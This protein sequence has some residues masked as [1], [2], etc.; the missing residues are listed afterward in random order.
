MDALDLLETFAPAKTRAAIR[1]AKLGIKSGKVQRGAK[2]LSKLIKKGKDARFRKAQQMRQHVGETPGS[3][4]AKNVQYRT[5]GWIGQNGNVLNG[6]E[7]LQL[8]RIDNTFKLNQ[9][10]RDIVYLQGF[11]ICVTVENIDSAITPIYF[12]L[13]LV[14]GKH[15]NTIGTGLDLFRSYSGDKR[16]QDFTD[17]TLNAFDRHCLPLNSDGYVV[18]FHE[19]KLIRKGGNTA[20]SKDRIAELWTYETYVPINRQ[21]RFENE[22]A[23]SET[24]FWLHHWSGTTGSTIAASN[25]GPIANQYRTEIKVVTFFKEPIPQ[26]RYV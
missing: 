16:A 25:S 26:V 6:T 13:A 12:N 24:K 20:E 11:K 14:S 4:P 7:L 21:I 10:L 15:K 5:D 3:D 18:H 8:P 22:Q 2:T 19:R 1:A 23:S 17:G 9:R